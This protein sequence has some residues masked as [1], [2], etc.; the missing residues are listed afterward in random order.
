LPE[1]SLT[2]FESRVMPARQWSAASDRSPPVTAVSASR[3]I[4]SWRAA[5]IEVL[6]HGRQQAE[7][8]LTGDFLLEVVEEALLRVEVNCGGLRRCSHIVRMLWVC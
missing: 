2:S 8:G 4:C 3:S 5:E 6:V 7:S 1:A